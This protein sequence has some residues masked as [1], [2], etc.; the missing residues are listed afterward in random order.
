MLAEENHRALEREEDRFLDQLKRKNS[1]LDAA[2][3]A[4]GRFS[5]VGYGNGSIFQGSQTGHFNFHYGSRWTPRPLRTVPYSLLH[6]CRGLR[7]DPICCTVCTY[8]TIY[9]DIRTIALW[10]SMHVRA[11]MTFFNDV[12]N[13]VFSWSIKVCRDPIVSSICSVQRTLQYCKYRTVIGME[14]WFRLLS[15]GY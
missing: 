1:D 5:G 8:C 10:Y 12:M 14:V 15:L 13:N 11:W 4:S 6:F 3:I 2:G 7:D 9:T